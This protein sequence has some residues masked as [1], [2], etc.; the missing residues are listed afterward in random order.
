MNALIGFYFVDLVPMVRAQTRTQT[1]ERRRQGCGCELGAF[2]SG[3]CGGDVRPKSAYS[4]LRTFF[5]PLLTK[6]V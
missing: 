3:E 1:Q 4:F 6:H 2:S 5:V